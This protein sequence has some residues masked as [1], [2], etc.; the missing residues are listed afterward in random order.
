[1][2]THPAFTPKLGE[3]NIKMLLA[4]LKHQNRPHETSEYTRGYMDATSDAIRA[5]QRMWDAAILLSRVDH[6]EVMRLRR[7]DT[8]ATTMAD[9]ASTLLWVNEALSDLEEGGTSAVG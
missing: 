6:D 3:T 2:T 7:A 8:E 5:V 1:M 4:H 9:I